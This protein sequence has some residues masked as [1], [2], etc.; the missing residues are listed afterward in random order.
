MV[1]IMARQS[2]IP[3]KTSINSLF[4][5]FKLVR[6]RIR[7]LTVWL[8]VVFCLT[9]STVW[10]GGMEGL[11]QQVRELVEQN[12]MLAE[13]LQQVEAELKALK[14]EKGAEVATHE[15][16]SAHEEEFSWY[17]RLEIAV[18]A[19]GV[20][21]SA[22]YD[23]DRHGRKDSQANGSYSVDLEVASKVGENGQ[24]YMLVETGD[25]EGVD[26]NFPSFGGVNGDAL[27]DQDFKVSEV[28][29]EHSWL[30]DFFRVRVGKL[31][32]TTDFDTNNVAND[33][34]TQFLGGQFINNMTVEFPDYCFGAMAWMYPSDKLGIGLGY[35]DAD[36]DWD[37]L[38]DNPF[39]I[40]EVDLGTDFFG[41]EGNYRLYGWIN[42][43]RHESWS[44][45][46]D[47][48]GYGF[49]VSV[50]QQI[51]PGVTLFA[52]YGYADDDI[53][54]YPVEHNISAGFQ[55]GGDIWGRPYDVLAVAWGVGI[56][57]DDYEDSLEEAGNDASDEHQFELYY[58]FQLN[59]NLAITPDFQ[60]IINPEGIDD[61]DDIYVLG[62]RSQLNF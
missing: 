41:K 37:D 47:E 31:D 36:S 18:G 61:E 1:L 6:K 29:Y 20:I 17:D 34:T 56:L 40:A 39:G 58:S 45:E 2:L 48:Q 26:G 52:R 43:Q 50:D 46:D 51:Y 32:L 7:D 21:Q 4:R 35:G 10:A 19:T 23:G 8:F 28:W 42:S 22:H 55:I 5:R 54:D 25:G 62:V 3:I 33:E 30:D 49:G 27:G 38:F 12:R 60:Y 14:A 9:A 15:A 57:N 16:E 11:E 24:T 59:D 44:G 13:R 53:V